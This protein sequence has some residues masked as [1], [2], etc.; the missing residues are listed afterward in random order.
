MSIPIIA[1]ITVTILGNLLMVDSMRT[2]MKLI[3]LALVLAA[4]L[5]ASIMSAELL[6][7]NQTLRR[8]IGFS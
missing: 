7:I 4:S 2:I 1:T 3:V 8:A 6:R 5:V